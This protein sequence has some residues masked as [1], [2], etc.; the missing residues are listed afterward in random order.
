MLSDGKCLVTE[1]CQ[2]MLHTYH[3][4]TFMAWLTLFTQVTLVMDLIKFPWIEANSVLVILKK[5]EFLYLGLQLTV[6]K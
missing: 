4:I 1:A 3:D 2:M 5:G 6:Q